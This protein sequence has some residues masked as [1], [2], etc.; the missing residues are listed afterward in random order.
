MTN[1]YKSIYVGLLILQAVQCRNH[2]R[3]VFGV[4][5]SDSL[6]VCSTGSYSPQEFYLN[7]CRVQVFIPISSE[8]SADGFTRFCK[9]ISVLYHFQPIYALIYAFSALTVLVGRQEGHP[10]CKNMGDGG[11]LLYTSPSPRDS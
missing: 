11:C 7:V 1:Y 4:D 6:Y 5:G 9:C 2:I 8:L 10:A 3:A